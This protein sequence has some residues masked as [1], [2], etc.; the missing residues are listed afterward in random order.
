MSSLLEVHPKNVIVTGT[1]GSDLGVVS[2]LLKGQG[3]LVVYP[4]QDL[5]VWDGRR[6]E[7]FGFNIEVERIHEALGESNSRFSDN[8]PV[9]F[10]M[11]HPGPREFVRQFRGQ[12]AVISGMCIAPRLDAWVGTA[13][14]V[15]NIQASE[16]E[17]RTRLLKDGVPEARVAPIREHQLLHLSKHLKG[18]SKVFTIT[19]AEVKDRRF[20]ALI[21]FLN[22]V[23]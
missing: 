21:S 2:L 5:E 15:V 13:D 10:E 12:P 19:N 23:F 1:P 9:Y 7:R 20:D 6:Y 3:W 8:L 4:G 16:L 22:S 18:F 14:I 17:D 11:P